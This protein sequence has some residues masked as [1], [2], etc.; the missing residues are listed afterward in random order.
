MDLAVLIGGSKGG[1]NDVIQTKYQLDA[2]YN[3]ADS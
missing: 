3:K 2:Q 1:L